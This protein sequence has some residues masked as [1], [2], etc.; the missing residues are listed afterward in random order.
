[1]HLFNNTLTI[2]PN[3][4][5]ILNVKHKVD[6]G[7][8]PHMTQITHCQC[9][10]FLTL[11]LNSQIY[12]HPC[13]L[14]RWI[15]FSCMTQH[16]I[17]GKILT[18][19]HKLIMGTLVDERKWHTISYIENDI[20]LEEC[21]ICIYLRQIPHLFH[22]GFVPLHYVLQFYEEVFQIIVYGTS[23]VHINHIERGHSNTHWDI[24]W[25]STFKCIL[26]IPHTMWPTSCL[27]P[28]G[29]FTRDENKFI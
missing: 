16:R 14:H 8:T 12:H 22:D 7:L 5:D 18:S 9:P 11:S 25:P 15:Y 4:T 28:N 29:V 23:K 17:I 26:H 1:M 21:Y 2:S 19:S 3:L 13:V 10:H 6:H 27:S 24:V 20:E